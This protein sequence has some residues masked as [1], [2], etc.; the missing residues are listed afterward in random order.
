[1]GGGGPSGVKQPEWVK[2][3]WIT[4]ID[5]LRAGPEPHFGYGGT[6]TAANPAGKDPKLEEGKGFK[7]NFRMRN[8]SVITQGKEI[9]FRSYTP[10][11]GAAFNKLASDPNFSALKTATGHLTFMQTGAK[12][13]YLQT[14]KGERADVSKA[15]WVHGKM[16]VVKRPDSF[17][18]AASGKQ[19]FGQVP[20]TVAGYVQ[21]GYLKEV[22]LPGGGKGYRVLAQGANGDKAW[23]VLHKGGYSYRQKMGGA[24][25]WINQSSWQKMQRR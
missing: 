2:P 11:N 9:V 10:K 16:A 14:A 3:V 23:S 20:A 25:V 1:M 7:G 19:Q 22:K 15:A 17:Q 24:E 6:G 18:V 5:R 12:K 13:F 4:D 8:E 21:R